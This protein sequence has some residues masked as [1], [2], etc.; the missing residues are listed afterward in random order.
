MVVDEKKVRL[1]FSRKKALP[2]KEAL[3]YLIENEV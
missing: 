3:F 2:Q 1:N